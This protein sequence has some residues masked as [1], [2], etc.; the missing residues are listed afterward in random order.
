MSTL[1][2]SAF[3][4]PGVYYDCSNEDDRIDFIH[5][6]AG[7]DHELAQHW[8]SS[9]ET[10]EMIILNYDLEIGRWLIITMPEARAWHS[11]NQMQ[12]SIGQVFMDALRVDIGGL[13]FH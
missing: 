9:C 11:Q 10:G 4:Q 12:R 5:T 3:N 6:I 7:G 13:V 2:V 8:Y 1:L